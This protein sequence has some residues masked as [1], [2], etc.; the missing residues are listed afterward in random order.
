MN[1]CLYPVSP[2]ENQ[3]NA[4]SGNSNSPGGLLS[5][6]LHLFVHPLDLAVRSKVLLLTLIPRMSFY[7]L[8]NLLGRLA[9]DR[10]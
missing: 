2:G 4:L 10:P 5:A 3:A 1:F 7:T 9:W 8:H 6:R